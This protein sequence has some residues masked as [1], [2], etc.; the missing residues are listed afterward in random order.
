[1]TKDAKEK[2][3]TDSARRR[4]RGA[5]VVE[6]VYNR[7]HSDILCGNL[8]P[9]SRLPLDG[10]SRDYGVGVNSLREALTRLTAEGLVV[11]GK[12]RG[13]VVE[14]VSI[15]DLRDITEI[16][17]FLECKA[18]EQ[19]IEAGD[20]DW[21]GRL[22]AAY[23][24]L[25]KAE[26]K[27]DDDPQAYGLLWEE[28]NREFHHE[29]ISACPSRWL[30]H[31]QGIMYRQS[32]RYRMLSLIP[33]TIPRD[34]SHR[35]HQ[36]ILEATLERDAKKAARLLREHIVKFAVDPTDDPSSGRPSGDS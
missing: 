4:A 21:E 6:A 32:Q 1:M 30:L 27:L 11:T 10:I 22:V 36:A 28:R 25:S 20:L 2:S 33:N 14:P 12:Q 8:E 13:F 16:R 29:L 19:A 34:V 18:L 3:G 7:L 9:D 35:E 26:K 23:H 31:F 5:P 24:K 17:Q 15:A